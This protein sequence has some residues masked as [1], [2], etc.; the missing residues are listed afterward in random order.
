MGEFHSQIEHDGRQQYV[1]KVMKTLQKE[2]RD[3]VYPQ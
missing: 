1:Y 3:K 2:E